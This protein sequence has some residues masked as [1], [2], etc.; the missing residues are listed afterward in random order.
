MTCNALSTTIFS[1]A[2]FPLYPCCVTTMPCTCHHLPHHTFPCL[3]GRWRRDH[4]LLTVPLPA[5]GGRQWACPRDICVADWEDACPFS[6]LPY[7]IM[8]DHCWPDW[9]VGGEGGGGMPYSAWE[10]EGRIPSYWGGGGE[11]E[12][13][14]R[15][16]PW[17][18]G[19]WPPLLSLFLSAACC[20]LTLFVPDN[21]SLWK[22]ISLLSVPSL[23]LISSLS[24]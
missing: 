5:S 4:H 22:D 21:L 11:R 19:P 15:R 2:L 8:G 18:G 10:T 17:G 12:K 16:D 20:S 23:F 13:E 14:E 9:L 6:A 1:F 7:L 3:P 24:I